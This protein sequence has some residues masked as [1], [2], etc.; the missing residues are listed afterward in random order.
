MADVA[1]HDNASAPTSSEQYD[2]F[3]ILTP[4]ASRT[5][6]FRLGRMKERVRALGVTSIYEFS[7]GD[8]SPWRPRLSV[9]R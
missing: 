8:G 3:R 5:K 4:A 1:D 7:I 2:E 9:A 6:I